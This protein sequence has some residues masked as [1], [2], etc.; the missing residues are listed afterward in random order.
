MIHLLNEKLS[1]ED[2]KFELIYTYEEQKQ[3]LKN[4]YS[5][6]PKLMKYLWENPKLVST[7][8]IN[9]DIIDVKEYLVPFI[10]NNFYS[11]ILS[12]TSFE[13]HL[14][15]IITLLLKDEISKSKNSKNFLSETVAGYFLEHLKFQEDVKSFFKTSINSILEKL[16]LGTSR[17]EINFNVQEIQENFIKTKNSLEK[18]LLENPNLSNVDEVN[19]NFYRKVF[20]FSC[21][22][23]VSL[24]DDKEWN[25][26]LIDIKQKQTFNMK[27]LSNIGKDELLKLSSDFKKNKNMKDYIEF[28]FKKCNDSPKIYSNER[29]FKNIFDSP[30]S[31]EVLALYQIDF[32]RVIHSINEIFSNFFNNSYLIPYSL[33]CTCKI[34]SLLIKKKLPNI[35]TIERNAYI[36]KYFF[37]NLF[38]PLFRNPGYGTLFNDFII[39]GR[40][41]HNINIISFVIERFVSGEFFID[42]ENEGDFSPFNQYFIDKMPE[43]FKFF[44][45][46]TNVK[47]PV[48][49]E[50]LINNQLDDNYIFDYFKENQD[51]IVFHRSICF[52]F[53][54]FLSLLTN[55]EKCKNILFADNKNISLQKTIEK[56]D[57]KINQGC[58]NDIKKELLS[59]NSNENNQKTKKSK[60][61]KIH[62]KIYFLFTDLLINEKYKYLFELTQERPNFILPELKTT[63]TNEEI[64]KNNII[65]VKNFISCLLYNY[66][67][68]IKTDFNEGTT[69]NLFLILTELKKF[70]KTSNYV[71]DGNIPSIWYVNTLIEYL[72]KLPDDLKSNDFEKL[73]KQIESDVNNSI[74]K[75]NFETMSICLEKLKYAQKLKTYY[76]NSE[77]IIKDINLNEK[78]QSIIETATMPVSINLTFTEKS[79]EFKIEKCKVKEK[80]INY[81]EIEL[82]DTKKD[83]INKYCVTI[84]SF[85]KVFPNIVKFQELQDDD[86]FKIEEEINLSDTIQHYIEII[87]DYLKKLF[88][89][90]ETQNDFEDII[91]KIYDY[92]MEKIYEKIY[93]FECEENDTEIFRRC[94]LLSWT[95]PKHFISGKKNYIYDSFLPDVINYF[96]QIDKEKSPRK[97][98]INMDNIFTC[99]NN[100]IKFN[101]SND[102]G[103]DEQLPIL[104]YAFVKA[105][106]LHIYSNCKYM[107]LFLGDKEQREEGNQLANLFLICDFIKDITAK[108]LNGVSE[109]EYVKK[110]QDAAFGNE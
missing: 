86:L 66:R 33:K 93:S 77:N 80:Q 69:D 95:E 63:M 15:Y 107:E 45:N 78:V 11:N 7:L 38:L 30:I 68:L 76:E 16:E 79:K 47:L 104:N 110:C 25:D 71:I 73:F 19:S 8:L 92:I 48:F 82:D 99:I 6:I 41:I 88:N 101:G 97:K 5:Y 100:V 54:C 49:V 67:S 34:I 94:V 13:D 3:Y 14:M 87:Q 29:F 31:K 65:K 35:T 39:S 60:D 74:K 96:D 108:K 44:D 52:S 21:D 105:R 90:D 83:K 10:A 9:S 81:N 61:K 75:L 32:F 2:K 26:A 37:S 56:L 27:Y 53:E 64:K 91:N 17:R 42:G 1:D 106:P 4:T 58:I 103:A 85:T 43:L 89:I 70:M 23:E 102:G 72:V 20:S 98:I 55:I 84:E 24:Y 22:N 109:E 57:N 50:K 18:Q 28:Q 59:E 36:A 12:S 40:T 62:T 46:M 51:E